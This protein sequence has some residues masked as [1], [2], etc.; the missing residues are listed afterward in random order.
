MAQT[1]HRV[2]AAMFIL[3]AACGGS[4]DGSKPGAQRS[5]GEPAQPA[6]RGT[7]P[8]CADFPPS[9][10]A[11]L[12]GYP[13]K[14]VFM[15]ESQFGA[16]CAY[17]AEEVNKDEEPP[18]SYVRLDVGPA[19]GEE[20]CATNDTSPD[21][22]G[23]EEPLIRCEEVQGVGDKALVRSSPV[24]DSGGLN[25]LR[26]SEF[27]IDADGKRFSVEIVA[28]ETEADDGRREAA[29]K[30]VANLMLDTYNKKK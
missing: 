19:T 14:H 8:T 16:Y 20:T 2:V 21:F 15:E 18:D 28:A 12:T 27:V 30:K 3:F 23:G 29:A 6:A 11:T 5:G 9:K 7:R 25:K 22:P 4:D 13:V 26:S 17:T 24:L 1:G 10:I